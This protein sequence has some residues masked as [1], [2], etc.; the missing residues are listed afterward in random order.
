MTAR[1]VATVI[2]CSPRRAGLVWLCRAPTFRYTH[3]EPNYRYRSAKRNVRFETAGS[4]GMYA[5]K[6]Q[7]L[8]QSDGKKYHAPP[9]IL[10]NL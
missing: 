5:T 7:G 10:V 8:V 3:V 4:V 6:R 2:D 9:C 1:G